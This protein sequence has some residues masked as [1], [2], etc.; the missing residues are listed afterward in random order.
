MMKMGKG[1]V[2]LAWLVVALL[3]TPLHAQWIEFSGEST[4]T[5]KLLETDPPAVDASTEITLW[6]D[7]A[8]LVDPELE[9]DGTGT[10]RIAAGGF[11]FCYSSPE[12]GD[13]C[14]TGWDGIETDPNDVLH[15]QYAHLS[16]VGT[17]AS[18]YQLRF[19]AI[20]PGCDFVEIPPDE[21][22]PDDPCARVALSVLFVSYPGTSML[23]TVS[24]WQDTL[25]NFDPD[26]VDLTM[27]R[28]AVWISPY[29]ES[30]A[31]RPLWS[32]E[33]PLVRLETDTVPTAGSSFGRIKSLFGE[34]PR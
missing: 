20:V 7:P 6:I 2:W 11:R 29:C 26:A 14:F 28:D 19:D 24:G 27:E 1:H 17:G 22:V 5:W 18:H 12:L 16:F 31:V 10:F 21:V 3:H 15:Y 33:G 4:G 34:G 25:E 30:D 23:P 8:A 32:F 13:G 9:A